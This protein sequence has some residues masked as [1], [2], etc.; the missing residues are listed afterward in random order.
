VNLWF[1]LGDRQVTEIRFV[2]KFMPVVAR[3]RRGVAVSD[4]AR[5]AGESLPWAAARRRL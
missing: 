5:S 3:V 4:R 2:T 1:F